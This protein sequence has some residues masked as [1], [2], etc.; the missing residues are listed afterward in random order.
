MLP[1]NNAIDQQLPLTLSWIPGNNTVNYDLYL[2]DSAVAEPVTPYAANI[3]DIQYII[4]LNS[5]LPY[6]K[7][8]KWKVVAKNPCWQTVGPI[9]QFRLIPLP[10]LMVSEFPGFT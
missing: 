4:P 7:T 3:S 10:D 1:A 2:W 5:G 9:Q 6:N 8:Y